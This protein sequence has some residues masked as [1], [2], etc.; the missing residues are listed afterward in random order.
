VKECHDRTADEGGGG[1]GTL[2]Y[3]RMWVGWV[4]CKGQK[5]IICWPVYGPY[6]KEGIGITLVRHV[7]M[8]GEGPHN[9]RRHDKKEK[10]KPDAHRGNDGRNDPVK[11]RTTAVAKNVSRC[12]IR[13][14]CQPI[15]EGSV[16][17]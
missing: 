16:Q 3:E 2:R 4:T 15:K 10:R 5:V 8:R 11:Y 9:N 17:G 6:A 13:Q 12:T 14:S 7:S 1:P